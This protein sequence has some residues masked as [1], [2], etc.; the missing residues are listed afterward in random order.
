M[1]NFNRNPRISFGSRFGGKLKQVKRDETG[2][3]ELQVTA[4]KNTG[5]VKVTFGKSITYIEL[6][7][8]KAYDFAHLV[9]EHTKDKQGGEPVNVTEDK[10]VAALEHALL[11]NGIG[12][13]AAMIDRD[14]AVLLTMDLMR[15]MAGEHE[16]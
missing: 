1:I 5:A 13:K 6:P 10:I 11:K 2:E 12:A 9:L 16:A 15:H 4:D 14:L 8:D 7:A 3:L